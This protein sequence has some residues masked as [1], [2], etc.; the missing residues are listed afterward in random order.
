MEMRQPDGLVRLAQPSPLLK[1]YREQHE[2]TQQDRTPTTQ[3]HDRAR[4]IVSTVDQILQNELLGRGRL[5]F[6]ES[7]RRIELLSP[8]LIGDDEERSDGDRGN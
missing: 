1:G 6:V 2:T 4:A 3:A 7:V 8:S 5:G